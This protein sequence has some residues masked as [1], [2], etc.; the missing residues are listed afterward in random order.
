MARCRL[1]FKAMREEKTKHSIQSSERRCFFF[2][3]WLELNTQVEYLA[4]NLSTLKMQFAVKTFLFEM[5]MVERTK[6]MKNRVG[7]ERQAELQRQSFQFRYEYLPRN[8][9][10]QHNNLRY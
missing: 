9:L 7:N 1:M 10:F 3:N 6:A 4:R 5:Q 2:A 8:Y